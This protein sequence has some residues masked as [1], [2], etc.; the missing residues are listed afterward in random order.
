MKSNSFA[1][2]IFIEINDSDQTRQESSNTDEQDSADT[3]S[4]CV[5]LDSVISSKG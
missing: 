2:R 4:C 1:E 3:E 5:N